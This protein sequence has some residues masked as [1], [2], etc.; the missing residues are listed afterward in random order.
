MEPCAGCGDTDS[1]CRLSLANDKHVVICNDK[2]RSG[3]GSAPNKLCVSKFFS[4]HNYCPACGDYSKCN[5]QWD[6]QYYPQPM[7]CKTCRA[8]YDLGRAAKNAPEIAKDEPLEEYGIDERWFSYHSHMPNDEAKE[9]SA[10]I[11]TTIVSLFGGLKIKKSGSDRFQTVKSLPKGVENV[12]YAYTGARHDSIVPMTATNAGKVA[13]LLAA[14]R[15][16]SAGAYKHGFSDG[17]R[18]LSRLIDGTATVNDFNEQSMKANN[19][20]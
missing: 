2:R 4:T 3:R 8:M 10:S 20:K 12:I 5:N 1:T 16:I 15:R 11:V 7:L 9:I 17:S 18:I 13:E 19:V 6:K 14:I